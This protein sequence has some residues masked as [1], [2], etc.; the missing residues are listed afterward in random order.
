MYMK[1]KKYFAALLMGL[2][3]V[4]CTPKAGEPNEEA[5][6]SE[7]GSKKE[8]LADVTPSKSMKD[9]VAYLLG[10]Y[11]GMIN[12]SNNFGEDLKQ[13][14]IKKGYNDFIKAK[15]TP[16]DSTFG[17]QFRID[18]AKLDSLF[19]LYLELKHKERALINAD[20]QDKFFAQLDKKEN[21]Q[22]AE[23]GLRYT[24][25]EA[26]GEEKPAA[27]D[28]IF[29]YYVLKNSEGEV[30]EDASKGK[31][32]S[33]VQMVNTYN[34]AGFREGVQLIGEGGQIELYVP[35]DLGYGESGGRSIEPN[36][37]LCF[38]ITLDHFKKAPVTEEP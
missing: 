26:G 15:G 32:D 7:D 36:S 24:I 18:P 19:N 33:P 34:I 14:L 38:T 6:T 28:T 29:V 16:S 5:E 8:T 22:K 37:P 9:S 2:A 30:I 11:Y 25:I 13:N 21:V 31:K 12:K 3:V 4:A 20:K 23:S 1:T 27:S 35:S 17:K 10:C